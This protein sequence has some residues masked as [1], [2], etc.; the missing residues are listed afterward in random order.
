MRF[1]VNIDFSAE[2]LFS[3]YVVLLLVSGVAMVAIGVLNIGGALSAGWRAFNAIAGLG[4][5]GY[6]IYLGFIFQGGSYIMFF[7]A[8]ILPV[9]LIAQWVRSL[10]ARK[11]AQQPVTAAQFQQAAAAYQQQAQANPYQQ[12]AQ[13]NPYQ[14]DAQPVGP[15]QSYDPNR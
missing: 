12:Q 4:F 3:S 10:G 15:Q 1:S 8:F 9:V 6:G 14:Q 13:P 11:N 5:V 2:P 7:K